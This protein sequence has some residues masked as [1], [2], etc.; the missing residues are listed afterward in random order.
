MTLPDVHLAVEAV[1]AYVDDALSPLARERARRHLAACAECRVVV[2]A[3]REAKVLLAAAPDPAPPRWLLD[4][5]KDIPMTADLGGGDFVLAVH[6]DELAWAPISTVSGPTGRDSYQRSANAAPAAV[7]TLA[8]GG[9]PA[10]GLPAAPVPAGVR[11]PGPDSL[12][13]DSPG[14]ASY[15][16][17]AVRRLHRGRR[18][19]VGA[20]AGLAF[21]M[22]TMAASTTGGGTAM[23]GGPGGSSPTTPQFVV[24]APAPSSP[25]EASTLQVSTSWPR[26]VDLVGVRTPRAR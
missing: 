24:R 21:G 26:G 7:G 15:G 10:P 20:F 25:L 8:A 12:G 22:I 23:P 1:A 14:T 18:G 13:P 17:A 11:H 9:W 3:Q 16:S 2:E 6:G 5:L 4:R 19:L